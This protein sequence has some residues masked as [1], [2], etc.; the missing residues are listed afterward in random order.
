MNNFT[1][2]TLYELIAVSV[3][4]EKLQHA[5]ESAKAGRFD[6][7]WRVLDQMEY[8]NLE[9]PHFSLLVAILLIA[10][11]LIAF[12]NDTGLA[13]LI[14]D[15]LIKNS[16]RFDTG[17]RL[18]SNVLQTGT[19][20]QGIVLLH[21]RFCSCC[22][23]SILFFVYQMLASPILAWTVIALCTLP[24]LWFTSVFYRWA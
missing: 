4:T 9:Q 15:L 5:L 21:C 2:K 3:R 23:L 7:T 20:L 18:W 8:L 10:A 6:E 17:H 16:Y 19:H 1:D 14:R 24:Y 13:A 12:Y 22:D 11:F